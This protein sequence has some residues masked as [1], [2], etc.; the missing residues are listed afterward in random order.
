MRRLLLLIL[1]L[2]LAPVSGATASQYLVPPDS[3]W[4]DVVRKAQPGDEIVL[5]PGVH[6][7]GD[8]SGVSG[9]GR[10]PI[11]VRSLS[12]EHRTIIEAGREGIVLRGATHIVVRDLIITGASINGIT[13]APPR[14]D[15][16]PAARWPTHI[17]IQNVQVK[18]TGPRGKRH[19]IQVAQVEHVKI[20]DCIVIGWGG[21]GIDVTQSDHVTIARCHLAGAP[22]FS[23]QSG[24]HVRG[25][26]SRVVISDCHLEDTGAYG[27]I[28]GG[29]GQW[30]YSLTSA[31]KPRTATVV[32]TPEF[33]ATRVT[34]VRCVIRGSACPL[35]F[36]S[37]TDSQARNLTIVHPRQWVC[38]IDLTKPGRE[39]VPSRKLVFS[40]NLIVWQPG[41]LKHF[42]RTGPSYARPA[43]A[44]LQNLWWAADT[45][46][47]RRAL[48]EWPEPV[49]FPQ[50]VNVDP[51]LDETLKPREPKAQLFGIY[52][53]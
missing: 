37:A 33:D 6:R 44:I 35:H 40:S 38:A 42:F 32:A 20:Q 7:P 21:A 16:D 15:F 19:G 8:L 47:Q 18:S 22:D 31:S 3:D 34:I 49:A 27:A 50:V 24:V 53:P 23:Q 41:E 1:T 36:L 25:G 12:P 52:S 28:I 2:V 9:T 4:Q 51:T 17:T 5:M 13:I 46:D 48:G 39:V 14:A 30:E 11:V 10:Q 43:M 26:S 29:E 45:P